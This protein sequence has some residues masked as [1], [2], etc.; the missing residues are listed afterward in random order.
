MV[1]MSY[2]YTAKTTPDDV[3]YAV[4]GVHRRVKGAYAVVTLISDRGIV[5][6][7][8]SNEVE[9]H[10]LEQELLMERQRQ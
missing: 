3:F 4:A 9:Q 8:R 7:K 10:V 1:H 2:I 6:F 5:A